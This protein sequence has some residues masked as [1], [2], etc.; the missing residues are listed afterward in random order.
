MNEQIIEALEQNTPEAT[1]EPEDDFKTFQEAVLNPP[2]IEPEHIPEPTPEPDDEPI[3]TVEVAP[4]PKK[5]RAPRK[6]KTVDV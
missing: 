3:E 1:N 4:I 2:V 6:K 5:K